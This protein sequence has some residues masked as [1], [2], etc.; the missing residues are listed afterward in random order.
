MA[1][2]SAVFRSLR[3][4]NY[5]VWFAGSLASNIGTW[6]QRTAQ[7]WLVL[8]ELTNDDATALGIVTG[9]QFGPQLL[10]AP[11]AGV[12]A[13]RFSK[14]L[15]L[16]I[17][18]TVMGLLALGLGVVV[19]AGVAEL[20]HVYAFALLL[21]VSASF[22]APARQSFVSELVT[23][24][25]LSNAVA[26]NS[27]SFNGAR[28]VGPAVAGILTV[29]LGPGPVFLL[30]ALTFAGTLWALAAMR[31]AEIAVIAR[32]SRGPNALVEGFRYVAGRRDLIA[33][34]TAV[35]LLGTFGLNFP[36][37][38]ATMARIEFGSDADVFGL[39]NSVLAIGSLTGALLAARRERARY[40]TLVLA[41]GGF[42]VACGA[43]SLAPNLWVFSIALIP[44]GF[45]ALSAM[46]TA[47]ALVQGGAEPHMRGR[48]MAIYMAIF[49]GGTPVG[50][51][52]MGWLA[53]VLGPRAALAIGGAGGVAAMLALLVI[54][55]RAGLVTWPALPWRR[56]RAPHPEDDVPDPRTDE[57]D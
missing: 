4:W 10:L 51:P 54:L 40:R 49:L 28:L 2:V 18:Q 47:N 44:V 56:T 39:L 9:L 45:A 31:T 1:R 20:W 55:H 53:E 48:V 50:A 12:L 30:N 37:F 33:L 11:F 16:A 15:V 7:S 22:D 5:R 14:R 13:D 38:T 41:L 27:T 32:P 29:W 24:E 6:M 42:G 19:V 8:T 21:G 35:F 3:V 46:T 23:P 17:T 43:A 57:A 36:V 52:L 34:L 26:L 25:L